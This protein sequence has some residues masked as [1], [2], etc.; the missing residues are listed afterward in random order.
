MQPSPSAET[1]MPELPSARSGIDL[2][3][4]RRIYWGLKEPSIGLLLTRSEF[5]QKW[6]A[7]GT[8]Q[9]VYR[10]SLRMRRIRFGQASANYDCAEVCRLWFSPGIWTVS[11]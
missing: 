4:I 2:C 11:W 10:V 7:G 6:T 5:A 9:T 8:Y 3:A 1:V